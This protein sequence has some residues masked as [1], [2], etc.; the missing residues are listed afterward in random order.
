MQI[1]FRAFKLNCFHLR[2]ENAFWPFIYITTVFWG[3]ENL[4][5]KFQSAW[6]WKLYRYH[7]TT[8][9]WKTVM[10]VLFLKWLPTTGLAYIIQRFSCFQGSVWTEI[11]LTMLPSLC[12]TFQKLRKHWSSIE[13]YEFF[14]C[15]IWFLFD[16][17]RGKVS[18]GLL[19]AAVEV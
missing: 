9:L 6:F 18:W 17:K 19:G 3:P 5:N 7:Q 2:M 8:N 16:P 10:S 11:I 13:I 15:G 4:E 12:I 1:I 14:F